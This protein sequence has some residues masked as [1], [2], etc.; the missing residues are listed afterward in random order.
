[1]INIPP[2]ARLDAAQSAFFARELEVIQAATYDIRYP[3]LMARQFIPVT[4]EAGP[5]A[6]SLT[7][8]QFDEVGKAKF[9]SN[10]AK[11]LPRVDV[12]GE[13]FNRPIRP[14]GDSYGY[15][16]LELRSAAMVGRSLDQRRAAAARRAVEELLDFTACFGS[17]EHGIVDGALNNAAIPSQAAPAAWAG[18]TADGIL[19]D[20]GDSIER[21][22]D[23]T[24]GIEMPDTIGLPPTRYTQLSTRPRSNVSDTTILKFIMENFPMIKRIIPWYR[25]ATAGAG[26]TARMVVMRL[27]PEVL[28]Q[29]IPSEFEQLPPQEQ[30]LEFVINCIATTAGTAVPL[31]KAID[32]TD[33]I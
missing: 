29:E 25:L 1:M 12:L 15:D 7:Y 26:D 24:K 30:G 28:Y 23:V 9:I 11:D 5:G 6:T 31:P 17:P 27:S 2:S 18:A 13:E 32:F 33:G 19:K 10:K 3:T 8:R 22:V 21:I 4:S 14:C 20:V 16:V